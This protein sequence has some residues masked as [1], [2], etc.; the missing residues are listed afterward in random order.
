MNSFSKATVKAIGMRNP[1]RVQDIVNHHCFEIE[2][3][4]NIRMRPKE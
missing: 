2:V 3:E 1:R 4:G